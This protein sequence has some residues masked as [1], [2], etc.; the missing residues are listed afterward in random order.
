M[1]RISSTRH[2]RSRRALVLATLISLGACGSNS[3]SPF[4]P[5]VA[6][7]TDN[8]QLQATNVVS[9]TS[10]TTY[11]WVNTG[12]RATINHSTTTAAGTTLVVIKDAAGVTVYSK[13]LSPSLN[14]PTAT[15]Q[16]GTW[17]IQ[18]TLVSYSGTLNF[19]AQKL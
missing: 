15:G 3:L 19:R 11:S 6:N 16:A 7:P 4:Q 18:L 2:F 9:V 13:A 12:T 5:Q 8:F 17:S 14:E 10:S 1:S